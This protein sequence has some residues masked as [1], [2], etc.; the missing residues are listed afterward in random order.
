MRNTASTEL[1]AAY[2]QPRHARMSAGC[3]DLLRTTG[4]IEC[5]DDE[6]KTSTDRKAEVP[7][8]LKFFATYRLATRFLFLPWNHAFQFTSDETWL[9]FSHWGWNTFVLYLL[10]FRTPSR[11]AGMPASTSMGVTSDGGKFVGYVVGRFCNRIAPR[12]R[13]RAQQN[14]FQ[15][16]SA[17]PYRCIRSDTSSVPACSI[18][19][20]LSRRVPIKFRRK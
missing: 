5:P 2:P 9:S 12:E 16:P 11:R 8:S 4:S 20:A 13:Q 15:G 18:L 7:P 19:P 3:I 6:H 1:S 10:D 14:P 17:D